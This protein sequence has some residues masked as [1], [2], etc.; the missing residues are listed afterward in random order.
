MRSDARFDGYTSSMKERRST[1][2][3]TVRL[4]ERSLRPARKIARARGVGLESVIATE[5]AILDRVIP[6]PV[7]SG[8]DYPS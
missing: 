3:T 1:K 7:D 8:S 6:E 4:P 5:M 2:T